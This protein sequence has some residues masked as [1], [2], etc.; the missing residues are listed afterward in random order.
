M[1]SFCFLVEGI[2]G[3]LGI[4]EVFSVFVDGWKAG[5][6]GVSTPQGVA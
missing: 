3:D 5:G 2:K 4:L 1:G 6:G